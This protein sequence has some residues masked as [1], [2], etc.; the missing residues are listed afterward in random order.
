MHLGVQELTC[1]H[2]ICFPVMGSVMLLIFFYFFEY[3]QYVY[4]ILTAGERD[5]GRG[6]G[7]RRRRESKVLKN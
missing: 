1:F 7:E 5:G 3:I 2:A 4:T 6:E